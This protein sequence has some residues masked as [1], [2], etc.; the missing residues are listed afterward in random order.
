MTAP[1][2]LAMSAGSLISVLGAFTVFN[3]VV[4]PYAE[5]GT[6][7]VLPDDSDQH[8]R[9]IK[10]ALMRR[11]HP[12]PQ[13]LILGNSRSLH[14]SPVILRARTG[15][16]AF[17]AAVANATLWDV[18][19]FT[20]LAQHRQGQDLRMLVL[21]IDTFMLDGEIE[22]PQGQLLYFPLVRYLYEARPPLLKS[23]FERATRLA[24]VDT[25]ATSARLLF[26][27]FRGGDRDRNYGFDGN[28]M[29][30]YVPYDSWVREGRWRGPLP[31]G[32]ENVRRQYMA[33]FQP[34]PSLSMRTTALFEGYLRD[35]Q[36]AGLRVVVFLPPLHSG[37]AESLAG[38][39]RYP[40]HL[41]LFR[42]YLRV[43]CTRYDAS[44]HDVSSVDRFGGED[45]WFIDGVHMIGPNNDL[46]LEAI[47]KD[48]PTTL[49]RARPP[50]GGDTP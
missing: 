23:E 27:L 20:R 49:E 17:N 11:R 13:A 7:I 1:R 26:H 29:I 36:R 21:G 8:S 35:A 15:L 3:I 41:T 12:P 6:Q 37:L 48:A 31:D 22:D 42:D 46:L 30:H 40:E 14:L 5:C 43:V 38:Q 9:A 19:A 39:T 44:F 2:F 4:D 50:A 33:N 18:L 24:S 45:R 16:R 34:P 10:V 25:A 32:F 47:L 28:G